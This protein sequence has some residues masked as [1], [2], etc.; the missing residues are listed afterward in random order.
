M[1]FVR[2]DCQSLQGTNLRLHVI[3]DV[4]LVAFLVKLCWGEFTGQND[5]TTTD[6]VRRIISTTIFIPTFSR[7]VAPN[8]Y[9]TSTP[10]F[11]YNLSFKRSIFKLFCSKFINVITFDI[12]ENYQE[13]FNFQQF[14]LPTVII[15]VMSNQNEKMSVFP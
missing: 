9:I 12:R 14:C 11:C 5:I 6:F 10:V 2:H 15:N 4:Y 13:N 8:V 3:L 7:R 1:V